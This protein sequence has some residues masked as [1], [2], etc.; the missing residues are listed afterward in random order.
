[1][2][3]LLPKYDEVRA[4]LLE[5]P[6]DP[7]AY[8]GNV[9]DQIALN[10][11]RS[12]LPGSRIDLQDFDSALK[13]RAAPGNHTEARRLLVQLL[14]QSLQVPDAIGLRESLGETPEQSKQ[15]R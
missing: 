8:A 15:H 10:K 11:S 9:G 5:L 12:H 3:F 6:L 14:S 2:V 7:P 13:H 1:M 4:G